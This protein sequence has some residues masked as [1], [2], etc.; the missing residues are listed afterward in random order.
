MDD[1]TEMN[2]PTVADNGLTV[3]D[4]PI[5]MSGDRPEQEA[6]VKIKYIDVSVNHSEIISLLA[7]E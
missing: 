4:I 7:S 3:F 5:G 6:E 2:S 1:L